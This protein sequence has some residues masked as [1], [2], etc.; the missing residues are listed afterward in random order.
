VGNRAGVKKQPCILASGNGIARFFKSRAW[1][2]IAGRE[3]AVFGQPVATEPPVQFVDL[4]VRTAGA[5]ELWIAKKG[6]TKRAE[7]SEIPEVL[8]LH[9]D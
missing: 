7:R 6:G 4:V 2:C 5:F 3:L 9:G 1:F 8:V